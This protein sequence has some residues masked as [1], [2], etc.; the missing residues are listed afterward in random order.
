MKLSEFPVH[1]RYRVIDIDHKPTLNRFS[2]TKNC[3]RAYFL[4][5]EVVRG[6][7]EIIDQI[8]VAIFNLD[9]EA[10]LFQEALQEM[11]GGV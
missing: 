1:I 8:P 4:C 2:A 7:E 11:P 9:S 3:V 10:R 5:R 6:A